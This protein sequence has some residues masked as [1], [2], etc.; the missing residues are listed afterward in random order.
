MHILLF[1]E[2]IPQSQ[3]RG[4]VYQAMKN[5]CLDEGNLIELGNIIN[6]SGKGRSNDDQLTVADLT[7][8]AVQDIMIAIAVYDYYKKLNR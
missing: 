6:T 4:E 5:G 8:V 7:Q 1:L 3:S 2:S